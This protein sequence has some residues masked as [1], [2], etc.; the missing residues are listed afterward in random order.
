M[1]DPQSTI[2]EDDSS[3]TQ[4]I[5]ESEQSNISDPSA[6]AQDNQVNNTEIMA[7]PRF[8]VNESRE[9]SIEEDNG[10]LQFMSPKRASELYMRI[11]SSGIPDLDWKFYGRRKPYEPELELDNSIDNSQK[12]KETNQQDETINTEFDF[13]EEFS[14]AKAET[15]VVSESLKLKKRPEVGSE[16]KTNLSDIMSDIMKESHPEN[17]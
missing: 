17:D 16:K 4:I 10:I 12:S 6:K 7:V 15:S 5:G 9:I 13:D 2:I 11:H 1:S 8:D 14:D 3:A